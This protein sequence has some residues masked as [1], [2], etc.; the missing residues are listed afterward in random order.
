MLLHKQ[1]LLFHGIPRPITDFTKNLS[2]AIEMHPVQGRK[3]L[4]VQHLSV[5]VC[6]T[7]RQW[8]EEDS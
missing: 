1:R 4:G 2:L 5:R 8:S 6:K 7:L 3:V